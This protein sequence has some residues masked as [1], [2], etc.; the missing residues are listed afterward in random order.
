MKTILNTGSTI[1][2]GSLIKGGRKMSE[3]YVKEVAVCHLNP[4]DFKALWNEWGSHLDKVK[5]KTEFSEVTVRVKSSDRVKKG[6]AFIPRG[7]WANKIVY[8][9][10]FDSGSPYYKGMTVEIVPT[11]EKV[12]DCRELIEGYMK[13]K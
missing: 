8:A 4:E 13:R 1:Q 3:D 9:D 11:D 7:P 10:T 5:I 2:Q 12:L 6:Q